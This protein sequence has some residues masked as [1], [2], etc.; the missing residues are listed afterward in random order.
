MIVTI[1]SRAGCHSTSCTWTRS[2]TSTA[3]GWRPG[4]RFARVDQLAR[5]GVPGGLLRGVPAGLGQTRQVLRRRR[6]TSMIRHAAATAP[7]QLLPQLRRRG[8]NEAR[9]RG[10][11]GP[12]QPLLQHA[13]RRLARK[14][15]GA[16]RRLRGQLRRRTG[17]LLGPPYTSGAATPAGLTRTLVIRNNVLWL[18]PMQSVHTGPKPGNGGLFKWRD[19]NGHG[20]RVAMSGNTIRVD[21]V[22]GWGSLTFPANG[23][24]QNNIIV[25]TGRGAY[26]AKVPPGVRVLRGQ[27]AL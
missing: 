3:P 25:W 23:V 1:A 8:D 13:R 26:P 2:R 4:D 6:G 9:C 18:K 7:G 24:Y 27:V 12:G 10:L 11:R 17:R 5:V 14:R 19:I 15:L 22:G 16:Q 20:M 21:K